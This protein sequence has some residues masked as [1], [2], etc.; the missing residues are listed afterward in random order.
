MAA[1]TALDTSSRSLA[2]I[3]TGSTLGI[4]LK[5]LFAWLFPCP[6]FHGSGQEAVTCHNSAASAQ[7]RQPPLPAPGWF[8][9]VCLEAQNPEDLVGSAEDPGDVRCKKALL[10]T[11][12]RTPSC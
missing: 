5:V 6:Y 1:F 9:N 8:P 2:L 11:E 7:N 4:L 10:E 12:V 3:F